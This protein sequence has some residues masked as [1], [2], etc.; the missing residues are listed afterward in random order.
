MDLISG[1]PFWP[2]RNG[3]IASYPA[4][5]S[6]VE[7]QVAVLGA[8]ITGA[9]VAWHLAEAG[10]DVVVVDKRDVA[11]GSTA[12]STCLL[13]YELDVPLHRL[14]QRVGEDH[15]VRAYRACHVALG[16][17]AKIDRRLGGGH[18]FKRTKSLQGASRAEHVPGLRRELLLRRRHGFAVEWWSRAQLNRLSTLP[19]PAAL[20]VLDAAQVDGHRLTHA[21]LRAAAGRGA[22]I[23]DRTGVT[24]RTTTRH[25]ITLR[26]DRGPIIRAR[27]LIVAT[28]Y[29]TAPYL[30]DA[31]T[32]LT[33]TFALVTEPRDEFS[34]W[35]GNRL[36]WET[37]R[38]Y[39]Y[40][41]TT[42]D[43]RALIGGYDEPGCNPRRREALLPQKTARLV[44]RF[45]Q[46]LPEAECEV[47]CSW[48][49][50]FAETPDGLPYIGAHPRVPHTLFALG[51]G[52]N[53][54]VFSLIAAEIIRDLVC[55][56]RSRDADLFRFERAL[57][58]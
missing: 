24:R 41:R 13:Q 29:E 55:E 47:A 51:Y 38:P 4:L 34:G 31:L 52:G 20:H 19:Y 27:R 46:L 44:R 36:I 54:I 9:L 57:A 16:T 43:G 58:R 2:L 35:P 11:T 22:R 30:A 14:V 8:G 37:A 28:G 56:G 26:T 17:L 49:G 18:G 3:L 33:S 40:L 32:Q 25:G 15:A 45:G 7:C 12:A 21:L 50:T 42:D 6:S 5:D 48:A 10:V 23:Y 1:Q 39:V 53:G